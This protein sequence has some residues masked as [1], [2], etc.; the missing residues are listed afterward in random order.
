[1]AQRVMEAPT[2]ALGTLEVVAQF[3]GPMPTGV[4]VSHDG[5]VFVCFPRWGDRV[6]FTVGEIVDGNTI[7]Y[8]N[9]EV[10]HPTPADPAASLMSVQSVVVDPANRLCFPTPSDA[11]G[12]D[13]ATLATRLYAPYL[14]RTERSAV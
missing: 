10:N 6:D 11:L 9:A 1:M 12:G 5:R 14:D 2:V 8:P 3:Y 4:T 7:A 13:F